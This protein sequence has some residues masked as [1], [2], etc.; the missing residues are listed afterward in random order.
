MTPL[1][2]ALFIGHGDPMNALRDNAFTQH[3]RALG[4]QLVPRPRAILVVSAH[5]LTRGTWVNE[6]AKP[7]TIYDFGGFPDALYRVVYAAPGAPDKARRAASLDPRIGL[8]DDWG[9]D[10]GAWTI[11][12]HIVPQAD[13]PVFQLSIDYHQPPAHHLKLAHS[14]KALRSEGVL[15]VGSGNVVHNLKLAFEVGLTGPA[16][17]WAVEFDQWVKEA[18]EAKDWDALANWPTTGEMGRLSVPTPDHYYPLLY[19]LGVVDPGEPMAFVHEEV[20]SSMSMRC[21]RFG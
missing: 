6:I 13:I 14:L 20:V 17:P 7:E 16:Y 11:L 2:P 1:T 4:E 15:I 10:H 9:L 21:V 19:T 5:W 3:L 8:T 12:R 18:L